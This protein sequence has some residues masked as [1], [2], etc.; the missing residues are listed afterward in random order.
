MTD[1]AEYIAGLR[2][3]ADLLEAHDEL[4]LPVE[5][6]I[7]AINFHFLFDDD[8]RTAL[9][10]A[11]RAMP[12]SLAKNDP[13]SS[14]YAETYFELAGYLRGLEV[15]LVAFREQVCERVVV[16]RREVTV[17]VPDPEA[18]AEVPTVTETH[19]VET[20]EWRCHPVLAPAVDGGA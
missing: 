7:S 13:A 9:A 17:E 20:V 5:G 12:I 11:V 4:P 19:T 10:D 15:K 6:R 3:L 14:D 18:L 2:Q 16:D 8:P 1:R